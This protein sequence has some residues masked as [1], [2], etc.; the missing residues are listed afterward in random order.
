MTGQTLPPPLPGAKPDSLRSLTWH[1]YLEEAVLPDRERVKPGTDS[2]SFPDSTSWGRY[3]LP[4]PQKGL[5]ILSTRRIYG[6]F[7]NR[8]CQTIVWANADLQSGR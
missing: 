6:L 7:K 1:G 3:S 2:T 5:P 8:F 4:F